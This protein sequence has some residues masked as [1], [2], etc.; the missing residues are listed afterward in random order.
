MPIAPS[1]RGIGDV[2]KT[3]CEIDQ[4]LGEPIDV[5]H[6]QTPLSSSN[7]KTVG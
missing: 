2:R 4:A 5:S 7:R 6:F 3:L 1:L